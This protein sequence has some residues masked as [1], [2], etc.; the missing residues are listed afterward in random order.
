MGE[1]SKWVLTICGGVLVCGVASMLTPGKSMEKVMNMVLGLFMLCCFLL[2]TGIDF[3]DFQLSLDS[4]EEARQRVAEETTDHFRHSAMD[5]GAEEAESIILGQLAKYG[6]KE[7]EILI[8][9]D[10]EE[11]TPGG[12]EEVVVEVHLPQRAKED[13]RVIHKALEYELGVTVR[14]EYTEEES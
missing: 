8:Y 9:M 7:D 13:H 12:E 2:P 14:L 4:P 3:S 11:A 1:I 6:I 10:T 5:L